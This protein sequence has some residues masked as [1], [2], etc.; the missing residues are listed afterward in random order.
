MIHL[1]SYE[2]SKLFLGSSKTESD[3]VKK[4]RISDKVQ[5]K[6]QSQPKGKGRKRKRKTKESKESKHELPEI[7]VI[8]K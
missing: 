6:E 2:F 1:I 8:P 4:V 5:V 7:R 3:R